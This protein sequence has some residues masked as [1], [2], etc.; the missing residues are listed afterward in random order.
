S[1]GQIKRSGEDGRGQ[2]MAGLIMGYISIGLGLLAIIVAAV[3][4]VGILALLSTT[5]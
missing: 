4:G 1:L 3:V 5:S 2:A